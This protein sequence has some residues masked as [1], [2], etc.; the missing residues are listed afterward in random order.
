MKHFK[1]LVSLIEPEPSIQSLFQKKIITSGQKLHK[2]SYQSFWFSL[3]LLDF[4]TLI[5]L[6]SPRLLQPFKKLRSYKTQ[7]FVD[8]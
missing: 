1:I 3:V 7:C 6:F 5:H 8:F 4:L 2:N